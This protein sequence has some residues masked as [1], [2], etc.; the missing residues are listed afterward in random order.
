MSKF[1]TG[2]DLENKL[3]DIIWEAK[4]YILIISP[5]IKTDNYMK[6][7]FS[8]VKNE[9]KI[10]LI[11]LFGKNEKRPENSL[12]KKDLEFFKQ[13]QKV[14]ILYHKDLHAKHYC[15]EKEGLITSLN[16]YDYSMINNVEYGVHFTNSLNPMDTLFKEIEQHSNDLIFDESNCIYI[17]RPY[18]TKGVLG[19]GKSFSNSEVLLNLTEEFYNNKKIKKHFLRDF[20]SELTRKDLKEKPSRE[21][22]P[23]RETKTPPIFK[24]KKQ[25]KPTGYCI[26]TGIEIPYNLD[27]PMSYKAFKE[28]DKYK[29]YDYP[30]KFCHRTAKKSNGKTSMKRPIL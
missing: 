14:S 10:H 12:N 9:H 28:W 20:P 22:K 23:K 16:L 4:K 13:F 5:F 30:E 18:Y 1:L 11:L 24:R 29:N 27:K 8:K 2:K 6:S 26:R 19:I 3:T 15:N 17:K 25:Q 7:V 21:R